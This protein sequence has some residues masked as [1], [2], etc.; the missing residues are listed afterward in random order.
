MQDRNLP[1]THPGKKPSICSLCSIS[2]NSSSCLK[3]RNRFQKERNLTVVTCVLNN[4]FNCHLKSHWWPI[5][6]PDC[7]CCCFDPYWGYTFNIDNFY[8]FSFVFSVKFIGL[9][10]RNVK[11]CKVLSSCAKDSS[12][13]F[14]KIILSCTDG[15]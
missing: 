10:W 6:T 7:S 5:P 8:P 3:S 2:F 15:E 4:F 13:K 14:L 11:M 12:K 9:C 1:S